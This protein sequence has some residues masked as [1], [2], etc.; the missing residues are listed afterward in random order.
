[1][2]SFIVLLLL[3]LS[4]SLQGQK[5]IALEH[6]ISQCENVKNN[7]QYKKLIE[8]ATIGIESSKNS[9]YES[10]FNFYK[11]YGLEYDNNQYL[12]AIPYFEKALDQ[13]QKGNYLKE[14][15]LALM[16]LN[17]LYYST[18]EFE[19]RE[20][21]IRYIKIVVDTTSNIYTKGIL[22]GSLGEYYLDNS[23]ISKFIDYKLKAIEYRKQFPKSDSK[24]SIN[25]GI[26]YSQIG[27]AYSKMQQYEKGLEYG[28]LAKPFLKESANAMAFLHNDFMKCFLG[29][30]NLDSIEWHRKKI[31]QLVSPE[32]SLFL[33]IS[34]ANRYL[35][36]YYIDHNQ[37]QKAAIYLK[38]ASYFGSKSKDLQMEMEVNL[39]KGKFLFK[40]R[41]YSEAIVFLKRAALHAYEFDKNSCIII[42]KLL[43]ESYKSQLNWQEA[44]K[45]YEIY[46][47][48]NEEVLKEFT[49]ESIAN[50]EAK[51]QNQHKQE[52]I[53]LLSAENKLKNSTIE[54]SRRQQIYLSVS[55]ILL[56]IIA[57]LFYK[58]S[59]NRK[60]SNFKLQLLNTELETANKA[61]I[62]FL[63][64]L[65]HDLRSPIANLIHFLR[66]QKENPELLNNDNKQRLEQTVISG[67]ENLLHSMEDILQ[68]SKSQMDNFKPQPQ[69][70]LVSE[71]FKETQNYFSS[72]ENIAFQ[73]DNPTNSKLYTDQ[74]YLK[75]IIRN[76]TSNAIKAMEKTENPKIVWKAWE[77]KDIYFLAITD[78]GKGASL[79]QFKILYDETE[80]SSIQNGLGLHLIRD[81]A[82]IIDCTIDVETQPN[83]GTTI[84]LKLKNKR[85]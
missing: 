37:L 67:A 47:Q 51:F 80:I 18:E 53:D 48:V 30:Q 66:L 36:E 12:A 74:N 21:L 1:M 20:D 61:K 62:K 52:K 25:I 82:K 85:S 23:E 58:Q 2:K 38:E 83:L 9:Y 59:Q 39:S 10:I 17:Y 64:I 5:N 4:T 26:S 49:K 7:S 19:K 14:E 44:L 11:G 54:N 72:F 77:E 84:I 15:T 79:D 46:N 33:N 3:L 71:I 43:A 55:F 22:Y 73:F 68:W 13:A 40:Q 27:Q 28:Y 65:N 29:L 42:H 81:L 56:S 69:Q 16:R 8:L 35:T 45:H 78:N 24:N 31:Y 41:N 50:A 6:L 76:L 70:T 34:S 63:S 32:D 57:F 75:T 60:K